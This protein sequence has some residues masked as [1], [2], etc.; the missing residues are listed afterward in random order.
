MVGFYTPPHEAGMDQ[1]DVEHLERLLN[2][3]RLHWHEAQCHALADEWKLVR[4][5]LDRLHSLL[6]ADDLRTLTLS[7]GDSDATA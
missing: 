5:S 3:M 2:D 1:A 7:T 6:D 4:H